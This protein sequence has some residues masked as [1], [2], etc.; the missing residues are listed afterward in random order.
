MSRHFGSYRTSVPIK[1]G[2]KPNVLE[3]D[4]ILSLF[5]ARNERFL[6][7]SAEK[8]DG[9]SKPEEAERVEFTR[10]T[11][12][13]R[14]NLTSNTPFRS[15]PTGNLL[16]P[17]SLG[18]PMNG[19]T[20]VISCVG[21]FGSN[22]Y[23]YNINGSANINAIRVAA[24]QGVKR[25]VYVSAADFGLM[26]YL[27]KGYFE[28]KRSTETELLDKFPHGGQVSQ[29]LALEFW[30]L[31]NSH[32]VWPGFIHGTRRV[33]SIHL[34]LS[35]IGAPLEMVLRHAK[36]LTRLPLVG[37]LFI[38]PVN[39]TSVAKVAVRAAVDP[40]FPSGIVDA[41]GRLDLE[42]SRCRVM[43][44]KKTNKKAQAMRRLDKQEQPQT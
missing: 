2:S 17:E 7:T 39:V 25:F 20:S 41:M 40:S 15:P 42:D 1:G 27:L 43:D 18:D 24:E 14:K 11:E 5:V 34:P 19:V 4:S 36:V 8:V 9:S 12:K 30:H 37:P 38:P 26:K 13:V 21:G 44:L 32:I 29:S 28:G 35:V 23:M 16:S 10:S 33:G 31:D 22:S 3:L 6:S